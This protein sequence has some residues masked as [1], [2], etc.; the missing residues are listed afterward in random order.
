MFC[1]YSSIFIFTFY[2]CDVMMIYSQANLVSKLLK[3]IAN[4]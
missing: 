4:A 1:H 3:D 2:F